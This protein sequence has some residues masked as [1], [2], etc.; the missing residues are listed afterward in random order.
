MCPYIFAAS[1]NTPRPA[2]WCSAQW[3]VCRYKILYFKCFRT[4][5]GTDVY[6]QWT[7]K[8]KTLLKIWL[9]KRVKKFCK[10]LEHKC[11]VP[12]Q[13]VLSSSACQKYWKQTLFCCFSVFCSFRLHMTC[14]MVKLILTC[15]YSFLIILILILLISLVDSY[16]S[17]ILAWPYGC[18]LFRMTDYR[19]Y[20]LTLSHEASC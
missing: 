14:N 1:S 16:K 17:L 13:V 5:L 11:L 12:L 7:L 2:T 3:T 10:V 4:Q 8:L 19:P 18:L 20:S 9:F 6:T 15:I